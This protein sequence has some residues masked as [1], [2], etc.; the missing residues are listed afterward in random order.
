MS[1]NNRATK[2]KAK[3]MGVKSILAHGENRR[4]LTV[5]GK[6]NKADIA[7]QTDNTGSNLAQKYEERNITAKEIVLQGIRIE[8]TIEGKN[9]ETYLNNECTLRTLK[10]CGSDF[11]VVCNL[12]K[13][14]KLESRFSRLCR[15]NRPEVDCLPFPVKFVQQNNHGHVYHS[16]RFLRSYNIKPAARIAAP[17]SDQSN[18]RPPNGTKGRSNI[19]S[20][21]TKTPPKRMAQNPSTHGYRTLIGD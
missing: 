21:N 20:S 3:R 18:V 13:L 19:W 6:G 15:R 12:G 5:F 7:I 17:M 16:Y 2:T 4:T 9:S 14:V 10:D 1:K 11:E 8:G